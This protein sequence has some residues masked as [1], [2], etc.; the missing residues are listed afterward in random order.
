MSSLAL[1]Q[2]QRVDFDT[3]QVTDWLDGLPVIGAPGFGGTVASLL[4]VGNGGLAVASI[5][6]GTAYGAHIAAVTSTAGGL[7]RISVTD[8]D[9]IVTGQGVA[10]APLYAGGITFTFAQ[11]A[12]PFAVGDSFAI[13]V[14]PVPVDL[15]GLRFDLDARVSIGAA[16]IA[17]RASARARTR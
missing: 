8:P 6:P 14:V 11:G 1:I 3:T 16:S 12:T 5:A 4:N 9:G 2:P 10:G 17:L 15:T 13:S 7:T